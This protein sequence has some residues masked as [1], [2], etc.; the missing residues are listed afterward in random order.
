M[1]NGIAHTEIHGLH[2]L[3]CAGETFRI[4]GAKL[5]NEQGCLIGNAPVDA[6]R[7]APVS[8]G[9]AGDMGA[10]SGRINTWTQFK[11]LLRCSGGQG[12]I[13]SLL[14]EKSAKRVAFRRKISGGRIRGDGLIPESED[15]GTAIGIAKVGMLIINAG[16]NH[17]EQYAASGEGGR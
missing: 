11:L 6:V 10:M 9:N 12:S 16:V 1:G 2:Q 8:G 15:A 3:C 7:G 17:G 5:Y 14:R 13:D 4:R